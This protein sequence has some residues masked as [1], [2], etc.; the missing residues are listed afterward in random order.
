MKLTSVPLKARYTYMMDLHINT[1]INRCIK[2]F[3]FLLTLS[4]FHGN[5]VLIQRYLLQ[6]DTYSQGDNGNVLFRYITIPSSHLFPKL[7]PRQGR[8]GFFLS[9]ILSFLRVIILYSVRFFYVLLNLT[10]TWTVFEMRRC[11]K[12]HPR[13]L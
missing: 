11:P 5:I 4:T 7:L 12:Y 8:N 10:F 9:C 6:V 13:L 1:S 2:F 3:S